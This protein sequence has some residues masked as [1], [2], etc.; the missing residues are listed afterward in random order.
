MG[1]VGHDG[2]VE[3]GPKMTRE[4]RSPVAVRVLSGGIPRRCGKEGRASQEV[5]RGAAPGAVLRVHRVPHLR[6]EQGLLA[7]A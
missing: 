3:L 2:V 6:G 5:N 7:P 1:A 4:P